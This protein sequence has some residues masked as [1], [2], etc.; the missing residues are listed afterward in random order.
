MGDEIIK[1]MLLKR[2]TDGG[3]GVEPPAF[4]SYGGLGAKL[5][6]A[7]QVL[8]IFWKKGITVRSESHCAPNII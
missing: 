5:P 1:L 8:V 3:L 4:A 7:N 2:V 6:A